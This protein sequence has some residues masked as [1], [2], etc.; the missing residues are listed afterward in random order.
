M[1]IAS[2][3]LFGV[4]G[5]LTMLLVQGFEASLL[6]LDSADC[7]A[8]TGNFTSWL[9]IDSIWLVLIAIGLYYQYSKQ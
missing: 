7:S 9:L 6:L 1:S 2:Y 4:L 8:L 3:L 5:M